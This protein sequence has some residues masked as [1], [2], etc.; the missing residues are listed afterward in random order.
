MKTVLLSLLLAVCLFAQGAPSANAYGLSP[1]FEIDRIVGVAGWD[2]LKGV[3]STILLASTT[4][5]RTEWDY[6]LRVGVSVASGD[7]ILAIVRA[8]YYHDATFLYSVN[9][10]TV[11][12][13]TGEAILLPF[14][15]SGYANKVGL[16]YITT[17]A[18]GGATA[19]GHTSIIKRRYK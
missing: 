17:A 4:S 1:Q 6:I 14:N 15:R 19:L 8:D 5:L 2:T 12:T 10:D 18:N 16:K 13:E 7:S 9:V 11:S 3:D